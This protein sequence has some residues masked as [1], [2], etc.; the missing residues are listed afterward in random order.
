MAADEAMPREE[1]RRRD[2]RIGRELASLERAPVAQVRAWLGL[3]RTEASADSGRLADLGR[4]FIGVILVVLGTAA[5]WGTATAVF[6]YDGSRPVNVVHAL[7]VF[8]VLPTLLLC[9]FIFVMLPGGLVRRVPGARALQSALALL[10]PGRLSRVLGRLLPLAWRE[11]LQAVLGRGRRGQRLYGAVEKW[12]V[13]AWSQMFALAFF[14][15]SVATF[16]ALVVF[17]DLAFAWS[18]TLDVDA[19]AFTRVTHAVA[20]PWQSPLPQAVPPAELVESSRYFRFDSEGS[21]LSARPVVDV[22]RLGRWWPFLMAAMVCYGLLPRVLTLALAVWRLQVALRTGIAV[23]PGVAPLRERMNSA[24]VETGA[25]EAAGGGAASDESPAHDEVAPA[26]GAAAAVV[27]WGGLDLDEPAVARLVDRSCGLVAGQ[28]LQ[29]GGARPIEADAEVLERVAA[30][31]PDTVPVVLVKAW[32]PPLLELLDW[33]AELRGALGADRSILVLPLAL[34]EAGRPTPPAPA[35][36]AVWKRKVAAVGD[37][38]LSV[39]PAVSGE[40]VA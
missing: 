7:A 6:Y 10:N 39:R 11:A 38:W 35:D 16:A 27:N 34:D 14:T 13:A 1:M 8:V 12:L 20:L 2:R 23:A 25:R 32:E 9:L 19:E 31:A 21:P 40:D 29:A 3:V 15:A 26:T 30:E 37:P 4:H 24:L 5:G 33:L 17:S 36:A 22:A 18:T 28:H